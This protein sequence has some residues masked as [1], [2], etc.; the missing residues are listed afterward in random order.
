M[1][2]NRIIIVLVNTY[3]LGLCDPVSVM[4]ANSSP[5][6]PFLEKFLLF[7]YSLV[8]GGIFCGLGWG[9]ELTTMCLRNENFNKTGMV[10]HI[11]D[12]ST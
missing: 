3:R 11:C 8:G 1:T 2:A 9:I 12:P 4:W 6:P 7:C 5:I 10:V